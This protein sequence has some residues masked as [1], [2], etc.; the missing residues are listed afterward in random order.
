MEKI[1]RRWRKSVEDGG[2]LKQKALET[3][4]A[5]GSSWQGQRWS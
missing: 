5:L 2:N 1:S 3:I 4:K